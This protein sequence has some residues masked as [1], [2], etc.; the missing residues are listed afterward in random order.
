[1]DIIN[2]NHLRVSVRRFRR[3]YGERFGD[4]QFGSYRS[5]D[6]GKPRPERTFYAHAL[7]IVADVKYR[8]DGKYIVR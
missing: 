5:N 1:M 6:H 8:P 7:G 4:L 2:T 3:G